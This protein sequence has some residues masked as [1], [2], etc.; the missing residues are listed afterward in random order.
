[1]KLLLIFLDETDLWHDV[2][3][4]EAMVRRLVRLGIGGATVTKG[5]MG[6]GSHHKVHGR[7]LL[8]MSDDRPITL[9]VVETEAKLR[10]V[11]PELRTMAP[12]AVMVLVAAEAV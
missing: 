10:G 1:M 3:M 6:Y 4:Y 9:M 12:E 5:I 8:G 11:L 7:G 2:P